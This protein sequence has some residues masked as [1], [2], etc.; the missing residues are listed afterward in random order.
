MISIL[1]L[2]LVLASTYTIG[3]AILNVAKPIFF[4][5]L[6]MTLAG[7][8]LL[9]WCYIRSIPFSIRKADRKVVLQLAL[10]QVYL[11]YTI[12][13]YIAQYVA[14]SKWALIHAATPF[15][16][17]LLSWFILRES[18]T[19][20]KCL[21]LSIG[22]LGICTIFMQQNSDRMIDESLG[23]LPD[24]ILIFSMTVYS[25][26]WILMQNIVPYYSSFSINGIL[27]LVGGVCSLISAI[28]FESTI[29]VCPVYLPD[30][31]TFLLLAK[32]VVV[33]IGFPLYAY[34]LRYYS[35]TFLAF[36]SFLEPLFVAVLGWTFF[37]ENISLY[38]ISS[39]MLLI[40]GL[41][42]F[43]KEELLPESPSLK[44]KEL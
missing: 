26:S 28:L 23:Y 10:Y 37:G 29:W 22:L 44:G 41:Y 38:F 32:V 6:A 9:I 30:I 5:G 1:F 34:L 40:A 4:I 15:V 25:Y 35:V 14:S 18:L 7:T 12:D 11:P 27:M 19:T 16:T 17:A 13:F 39:F 24:L 33:V 36:S 3:K 8:A 2:R 21:G 42:I 31:F 20:R 43:Y